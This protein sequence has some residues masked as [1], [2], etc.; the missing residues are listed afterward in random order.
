VMLDDINEGIITH[1]LRERHTTP[2]SG[3]Y[4]SAGTILVALNPYEYHNIYTVKH[5]KEYLHPGNKKLPPHVFQVAAAA[6]TALTLEGT[7]QAILISGESGAGKVRMHARARAPA[8]THAVPA[9][10][11]ART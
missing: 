10:L 7:N 11:S 6:H 4:T 3:F 2:G 8:Y 5:V 9:R 1:T